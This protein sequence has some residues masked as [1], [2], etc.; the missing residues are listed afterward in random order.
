MNP[1]F[2]E[3]SPLKELLTSHDEWL[4]KRLLYYAKQVIDIEDGASLEEAWHRCIKGLSGALIN[5]LKTSYPDFE[6]KKGHDFR[7]D[8]ICSFLVNTAMRHRE[9]GISLEKFHV[10]IVYYKEAWLDLVRH[11]EFDS[12]YEDVCL[13][14]VGRMF[15]RMTVAFCAQWAETDQSKLIEE[16]QTRNRTMSKEKDRYLTIFEG[17]PNPVF[18]TDDQKRIV[19]LNLAGSAML[20]GTDTPGAQYYIKTVT[21]VSDK[22]ENKESCEKTLDLFIGKTT[23][24]VFPWLTDNLGNFIASNDS[25][26]SFEKEI[27]G[28]NGT[29][30]LLIKLSK[31]VD[32]R[33]MFNGVIIIMEDITEKKKAE[34]AL[35][36]AKEAAEAA[37][38]AKGD[39]LANMSH[40]LRT[41]LNAI[42]GFSE[43]L[44]SVME[45]DKE[46]SYVQSIKIAGNSLL[47]LINDILD[48]SKIEAGML[49]LKPNILNVKSVID[50]IDQIFRSKIEEKGVEF[51]VDIERNI[52]E[53]LVL[54][55]VRI[56]QIMLN[57]VGN[58]AKFTETGYIKV[59]V[60]TSQSKE[61][62]SEFGL[63]IAV[64]DSGIGI[65]PR[66][67]DMVFE[68]FKQHEGLDTRT[69][70][71]TGLGL[72]ICKKLIM[73]MGGEI[74]VRSTPGKGTVF[75]VI[76]K[77]V[78]VAV[79]DNRSVNS[80]DSYALENISFDDATILIVDDIESNRDVVREILFKVGLDAVTAENGKIAL[81]MIDK[82]MPDLVFMDIRMPILDGIKTTLKIKENP[83]TE[84]IPVVA[85]TVPSPMDN[86]E[87]LM[88]IGF[89]E[90]LSKPF[91]VSE[92]LYMLA[93]FLKHSMSEQQALPSDSPGSIDFERMK[94]P[95]E[96][97][98][99]LNNEIMS[100]CGSLKKAMI[101][102]R[103]KK[104]AERVEAIAEKHGIDYLLQYG[105]TLMVCADNIDTVAI[106][107][108]LD[109]FTE[110]I[111]KLNCQ[112][113]EFNE[114][115]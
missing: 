109:E 106:E 65:S 79:C 6:F 58:A 54:D 43:L 81:E 67:M 45:D 48:L 87:N 31:I 113:D 34:E 62:E 40:E 84:K 35:R 41:P 77:H 11:G 74:A 90:Y 51:I 97:M 46:K 57:L 112:W 23:N 28:Q 75:E 8:P 52:P 60:K 76:V 100:S 13:R 92:L 55:E 20:H 50:E 68:A 1:L 27:R 29:Q 96:L 3:M 17:V 63:V 38:Q 107:V 83:R 89:N 86:R 24:E 99:L 114:N 95:N 71:G 59:T 53:L 69:Y 94:D 19:D 2:N 103:I 16:L 14:Y 4:M 80:K 101:I 22:P 49:E 108:A 9:R 18:I 85:L 12:E 91:K 70:G 98:M 15:D 36:H 61:D 30:Y 105:R 39:F 73:A 42:I 7:H 82:D 21:L 37:N 33:E 88:K 102:S 111:K 26:A 78:P 93:K 5:G 104:F 115:Q 66:D 64:E 110:W 72:T 44:S 56:R 25:T 10:L 32:L 47:T